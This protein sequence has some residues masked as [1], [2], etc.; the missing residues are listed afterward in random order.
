MVAELSVLYDY[1][2][3][4]ISEIFGMK[5]QMRSSFAKLAVLVLMPMF[6]CVV[7][8][9]G[10]TEPYVGYRPDFIPVEFEVGP[11]G[12]S[13]SGSTSIA[14]PI[15]TFSIGAHYSLPPLS[16]G[17]IYVII[18]NRS[19]GFDHIYDVEAG[20]TALT[21]IVNGLQALP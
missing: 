19:S 1:L 12:I 21:A 9:G 8:C 16:S 20:T 11:S 2:G 13:V 7:A 10:Q 18:R 17:N 15:G 4:R 14:T 3:L 6:A 5:C